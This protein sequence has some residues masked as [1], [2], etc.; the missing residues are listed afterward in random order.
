MSDRG[1]GLCAPDLFAPQA[2]PTRD[3]SPVRGDTPVAGKAG[4]GAHRFD[5]R[6]QGADDT[7]FPVL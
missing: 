4:S 7:V 2:D 3:L 5:I 1:S 6:P